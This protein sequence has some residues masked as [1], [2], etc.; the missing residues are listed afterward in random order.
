[1][2]L[3]DALSKR[4]LIMA[5]VYGYSDA[6]AQ[7][8]IESHGGNVYRLAEE[9]GLDVSEIKDFSASI[10]PLGIPKSSMAAIRDNIPYIVHYPDP[11]TRMLCQA[12]SEHHGIEPPTILCANGSNELFYLII[13]ALRPES[14]LTLAPTFSE[15]VRAFETFGGDRFDDRQIKR[16]FLKEEDHF[17]IDVDVLITAM[18]GGM[19]LQRAR[20]SPILNSPDLVFLCNPN[21]PTASMLSREEVLKIADAAKQLRCHLVVDEAFIDFCPEHSVIGEVSKNPYLIVIRSLTKF[22]GLAGLRVGYGVFH[23]DLIGKIKRF[24]EPW[25]VNTLA[26][27]AAISALKDTAYT[28]QTMRL[29]EE[30]KTVLEDGFRALKIRYYPSAVNFY[31]LRFDPTIDVVNRLKKQ[32][33]MVRDCSN[34]IGLSKGYVRVAV[35]SNR[36]NMRLL[37]E[38]ARICLA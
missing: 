22:Y 27:V 8:E 25:T 23:Q 15:Y 7:G 20:R 2:P 18:A 29:M 38:L 32:G 4:G 34:F 14:V 26:Q 5:R 16:V 12:I 10:N 19:E 6:L 37:K 13:R 36:D 17:V 31:L 35:K 9:L 24:K 1:M 3:R 30:E 11:D 21:N 28:Q 33:I